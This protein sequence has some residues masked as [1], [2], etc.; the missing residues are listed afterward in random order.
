MGVWG[1]GASGL[2]RDLGDRLVVQLGDPQAATHFKQR[3]D[4][5]ILKGN[6]ILVMGTLLEEFNTPKDAL[7]VEDVVEANSFSI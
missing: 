3:L 5:S 6:V 7:L 2:I 4:V 1:P